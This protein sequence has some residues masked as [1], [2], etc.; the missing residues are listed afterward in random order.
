MPTDEQRARPATPTR[1]SAKAKRVIIVTD[2]DCVAKDAV[3]TASRNVGASAISLSAACEAHPLSVGALKSMLR[4]APHDPVV[5]MVDDGGE[6]GLGPGERM[7]A[8]LVNDPQFDVLGVIAVA[9]NTEQVTP[10][11]VDASITKHGELVDAP[12]DKQGRA[13]PEHHRYLEGDT[14]ELLRE[15]DV[16]VVIG[17]GDPGKMNFADEAAQGAPITTRALQAILNWNPGKI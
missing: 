12:V 14:A 10:V 4:E 15:V 9:S 5:V 8:A 11:E 17:L 2:G 6:V 1:K 3:E 13:E 16:P 7:V